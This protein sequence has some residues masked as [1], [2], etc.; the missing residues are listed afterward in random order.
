MSGLEPTPIQQLPSFTY[1]V[2]PDL[3]VILLLLEGNRFEVEALK[4]L[5]GHEIFLD[6]V[7]EAEQRQER[8]HSAKKF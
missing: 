7:R 8:K 5:E 2:S 1:Q 3:Q 4:E 6:R